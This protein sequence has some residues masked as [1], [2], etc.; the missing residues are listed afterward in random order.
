MALLATAGWSLAAANEQFPHAWY[1]FS[2]PL[3]DDPAQMPRG[4]TTAGPEVTPADSPSPQWLALQDQALT[5]KQRDR[6]AIL[7]FA[8]EFRTSF[9]FLETMTYVP[10]LERAQPYQSWATEYVFVIDEDDDFISLQHVFVMHFLENDEIRGPV[11]QKHWRQDWRYQAAQEL[12]FHGERLWEVVPSDRQPGTWTQ[13]VHQVDDTPRYAARGAWAHHGNLSVW[14]SERSWRPLPR[15]E[16]T[17]RDDYGAMESLHRISI[18]PDGWVHE[19]NN[20]KVVVAAPGRADP[21]TPHLARE[22]G[23]ARYTRIRDYDFDAGREYWSRTADYWQQVRDWWDQRLAQQGGF[24]LE[25]RVD[26]QPLFMPLFEG[27]ARAAEDPEFDRQAQADYVR[28]TLSRYV[29]AP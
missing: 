18:T 2:W 14:E 29:A 3:G 28:R 13:T 16:H 27:A 6:L 12:V 5:A 19:Q 1:T 25:D 17:V 9:D 26:D 4:G 7:A 10:G 22:Q 11:V 21:E 23:L 8:G 24:R 20:L 15:R